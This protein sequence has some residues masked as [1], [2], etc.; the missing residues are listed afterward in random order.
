MLTE[1]VKLKNL[2]C[3][4]RIDKDG[5]KLISWQIPRKAQEL[6]GPKTQEGGNK[7]WPWKKKKKK[8]TIGQICFSHS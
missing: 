8:R 1:L 4:E 6:K 2:K 7:V 5:N 3:A